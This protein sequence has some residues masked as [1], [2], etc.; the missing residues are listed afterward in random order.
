MVE[1][2][3]GN[4]HG[5]R[6]RDSS[7][8]SV[9]PSKSAGFSFGKKLREKLKEKGN[10][11]TS[12]TTAHSQRVI[13]PSSE[14]ELMTLARRMDD[15]EVIVKRL[16]K[17]VNGWPERVK[18]VWTTQLDLINVW[19]GITD[20]DPNEPSEQ[21][22]ERLKVFKKVLEDILEGPLRHLVSILSKVA[23]GNYGSPRLTGCLRSFM[24]IRRT[25]SK[26]TSCRPFP[27]SSVSVS[28]QNHFL[29]E[30][31]QSRRITN[32]YMLPLYLFPRKASLKTNIWISPYEILHRN[33]SLFIF[34]W[35]RNF[36][37][38]WK[39]ILGFST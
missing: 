7:G 14:A 12:P 32:G 37:L 35:W 33:I 11:D 10:K 9:K 19:G 2:A 20:I 6:S 28:I 23:G 16:G 18:D 22:A 13:S 8:A 4:G 17:Q 1:K 30:E 3:L 36:R 31:T 26:Q 38:I 29:L 39:A 24:Y 15:A 25:I 27:H 21:T 34:S 5:G